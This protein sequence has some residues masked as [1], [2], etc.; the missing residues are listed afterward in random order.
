MWRQAS[1]NDCI[2]RAAPS[3]TRATRSKSGT[4]G[5]FLCEAVSRPCRKKGPEA[6]FFGLPTSRG[7]ERYAIRIVSLGPFATPPPKSFISGE[8]ADRAGRRAGNG[9]F[10]PPCPLIDFPPKSIGKFATLA[11]NSL[12][13]ETDDR[14]TRIPRAAPCTIQSALVRLVKSR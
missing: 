5:L 12:A 14:Q 9:A 7:F 11:R 4:C 8:R 1:R 6:D 13:L 2:V 10:R 3:S